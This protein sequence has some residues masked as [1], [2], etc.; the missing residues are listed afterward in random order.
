MVN[1]RRNQ[2]ISAVANVHTTGLKRRRTRPN[3]AKKRAQQ[4]QLVDLFRDR[5]YMRS[6]IAAV[7]RKVSGVPRELVK[8]AVGVAKTGILARM[9][10][11]PKFRP[12]RPKG[13]IRQAV[14]YATLRLLKKHATWT[15][16]ERN[17]SVGAH[18]RAVNPADEVVQAELIQRLRQFLGARQGQDVR[19]SEV[20]RA[21]G[22][23]LDSV[24]DPSRAACVRRNHVKRVERQLRLYRESVLGSS[25]G[26][27]VNP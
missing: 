26:S 17:A 11:A 9:Q 5:D 10:S 20:V 23:K 18:M 19:V 12:R 6:V 3:T 27:C 21:V 24:G 4:P 25:S 13:Y 1:I 2:S 14:L 8:E 16:H 7:V 15:R 22:A